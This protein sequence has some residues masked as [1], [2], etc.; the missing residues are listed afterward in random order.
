MTQHSVD[1]RKVTGVVKEASYAIQNHGFNTV[2][3]MIGLSE[4]LGRVIVDSAGTRVQMDDL[5]D[6]AV[7]HLKQTVTIGSYSTGK[8]NILQG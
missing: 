2:E 8:S 7:K 3:V 6:A 4:L 1:P 5:I